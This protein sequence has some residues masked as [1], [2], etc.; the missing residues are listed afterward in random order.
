[1]TEPRDEL[2]ERYF[3]AAEQDLRRP[4]ARVGDAV[5]AH[6]RMLRDPSASTER[7]AGSART[8][9]AANHPQWTRALVASLAVIGL[10][11]LLTLQFDRA[12]PEVREAALSVAA[13]APA[14]APSPPPIGA[15]VM[16]ARTDGPPASPAK[17]QAPPAQTTASVVRDQGASAGAMASAN[18]SAKDANS[19][20]SAESAVG[21]SLAASMSKLAAPAPLA[22]KGVA[23]ESS[24]DTPAALLLEAARTGQMEGLQKLLAQGVAIN[25][26]DSN[27][28]TALIIAVRNRQV[29]VAR[30]LWDGG[31]DATLRNLEGQS[32]LQIAQQLELTDVVQLLQTPR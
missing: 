26:R 17:T 23:L 20:A 19:T 32:A 21:M 29:A 25:T 24:G 15:V 8:V 13:P 10:A 11:G 2:L 30:V 12:D 7:V 4:S 28:N 16:A 18:A 14:T 6:A 27:G 22:A 31:A 1:M 3:E 5:R 9:V